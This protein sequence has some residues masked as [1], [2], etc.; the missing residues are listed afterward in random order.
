MGILAQCPVCKTRQPVKNKICRRREP[1][2]LQPG[3]GGE[4]MEHLAFYSHKDGKKPD[5][6]DY[7]EELEIFV[8]EPM[9]LVHEILMVMWERGEMGD[10]SLLN[11]AKTTL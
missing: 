4:L 7:M 6:L 1:P 9:C 3:K 11:S 5:V 2:Y 10:S 8:K